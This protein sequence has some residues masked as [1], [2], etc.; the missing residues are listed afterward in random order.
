[1]SG[2]RWKQI[3]DD[4]ADPALGDRLEE[5]G[6][7]IATGVLGVDHAG[8]TV[9]M[10]DAPGRV[11]ASDQ[12]ARTLE[13]QQ[14]VVG[15]G[16][17]RDCATS[18]WPVMIADVTAT[19][20]ERPGFADAAESCGILAA[21]SFPLRVGTGRIGTVTGYRDRPGPLTE[22]E[23]AD[24]LVL[25]TLLTLLLLTQF[26]EVPESVSGPDDG[27]A[28]HRAAGMVSEQL[29]VTVA[30]ALVILRSH[31]FANGTTVGMVAALVLDRS[32][33]FGRGTST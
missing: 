21:F 24:G 5:R 25:S 32:I 4:L 17:V 20:A 33:D 14:L 19:R 26:S 12:L 22:V 11:T 29:G 31:A 1:M 23:Y 7:R 18:N 15:D 9:T 10:G 8:L 13:E 28:V 2:D 27:A 3:A 6:C 30:D 16:P